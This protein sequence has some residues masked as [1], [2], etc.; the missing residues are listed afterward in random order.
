MYSDLIPVLFLAE[1]ICSSMGRN[2]HLQNI[3]LGRG[4]GVGSKKGTI[5]AEYIVIWGCFHVFY[6]VVRVVFLFD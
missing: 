5:S 6:N 2:I 1:D 4:S 3:G